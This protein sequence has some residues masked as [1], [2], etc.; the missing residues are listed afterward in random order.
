MELTGFAVIA[1]TVIVVDSVSCVGAFLY[2]GKENALADCVER[3]RFDE[4][5]IALFDLYFINVFGEG[6]VFDGIPELLGRN[7]IL[8]SENQMCILVAVDDLPA[9]GFALTL[10]CQFT[11]FL[12]GVYLNGEVVSCVDEFYENREI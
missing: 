5:E 1:D 7:L 2:L 11:V 12:C 4:E 10:A 9:F 3:T 6:V 8:E